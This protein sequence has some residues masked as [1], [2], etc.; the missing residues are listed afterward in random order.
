M[1]HNLLLFGA[2][3][4]NLNISYIEMSVSG[5][6]NISNIFLCWLTDTSHYCSMQGRACS[7]HV[8]T[9]M[10]AREAHVYVWRALH[11]FMFM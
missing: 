9:S 2:R 11:R 7:Y 3:A 1:C 10:Y 8:R 5:H 6:Y 4:D